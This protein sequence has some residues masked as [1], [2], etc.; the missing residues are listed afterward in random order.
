MK[1]RLSIAAVGAVSLMA[2]LPAAAQ[3]SANVPINATLQVRDGCLIVADG[4]NN[5]VTLDFGIV[6]NAAALATDI[7][8]SVSAGFDPLNTFG[9][10]GS[11]SIDVTCNI[12]S[13][14]ATF[15]IGPGQNGSNT[16]RTLTN[17]LASGTPG[18][19]VNYRLYS[20]SERTPA[21]E[22]LPDGTKLLLFGNGNILAGVPF[23]IN[24]FGRIL[25]VDVRQAMA[26]PYTD[27]A[28][29]T[30]TF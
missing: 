21:S 26:G 25:S 7:F 18:F 23:R 19:S 8:G 22:Y 5:S 11:G 28:R 29:G 2:N 20:R 12:N 27:I 15:E 30:L 24:V 13:A 4:A 14:T 9:G 1:C 16:L 6:Q 3:S 17:P 10:N